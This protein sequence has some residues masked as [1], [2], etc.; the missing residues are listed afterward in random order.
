VFWRC[1][2]SISLFPRKERARKELLSI[3]LSKVIKRLGIR[4]VGVYK[5][6]AKIGA[7]LVCKRVEVTGGRRRVIEVVRQR[8]GVEESGRGARKRG[9]E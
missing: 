6:G 5:T 8:R 2:H 9:R 3:L 4:D 1:S 7:L